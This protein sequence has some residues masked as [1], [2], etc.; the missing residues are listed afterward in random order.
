MSDVSAG[1][2]PGAAPTNDPGLAPA[3]DPK[4]LGSQVPGAQ[5]A[6][7]NPAKEAAAEAMRKHKLKVDG[8]E[9]EVDEEELKRGYTHQKAANKMLQEGK[10]SKKQAEEFINMM[11]DKGKLFDVIKKLGHDPRKLS[12]EF[13]LSQL[14]DEM[15]DP[16]EK[17]FRETKTKLQRY[18]ELE[19]AQRDAETKKRD[20]ALKAKFADDYTKQ[21]TE[22]LKDTNLPP[23]KAAVAEMAKYIHRAAKMNFQMTPKEAAQL[24]KEDIETAHRN[25][26]GEADAETLMKLLGDQGLQKLRTYD[27]SR[28]KDPAA[29]L[30]TPLDQ[31]EAAPRPR[32]SG[33]RMS[34]AEWRKFNRS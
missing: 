17:E 16:R 22:A 21:F 19:K 5:V 26:Y 7:G 28:L 20:D 9:I 18:E 31:G 27:T 2:A 4:A 25:L 23:T 32:N 33:K 13:L 3:Q 8:Q 14:E 34:A 10:A 15:M 24:V 6:A 30:K 12:E 29:N 1:G 11:K